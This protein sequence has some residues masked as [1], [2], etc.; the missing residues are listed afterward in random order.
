MKQVCVLQH[1]PYE[2]Q[3]YIADYLQDHGVAFD[4][5]RLWEA[6]ALPDVS[7]WEA[8]CSRTR[9]ARALPPW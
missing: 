9:S 7:R 6:Y 1:V 8:S 4:V 5:V 2:G 3:G